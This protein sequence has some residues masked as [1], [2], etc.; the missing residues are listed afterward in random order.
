MSDLETGGAD[1][2]KK[3]AKMT[4]GSFSLFQSRVWKQSTRGNFSALFM[5]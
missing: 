5:S 1:K 2:K 3:F 4:E